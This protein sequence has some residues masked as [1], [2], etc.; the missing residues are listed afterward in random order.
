MP[1]LNYNTMRLQRWLLNMLSCN[2][3]RLTM[4]GINVKSDVLYVFYNNNRKDDDPTFNSEVLF[5]RCMNRVE[6]LIPNII[7][8]SVKRNFPEQRSFYYFINYQQQIIPQPP[9][10]ISRITS[11]IIPDSSNTTHNNSVKYQSMTD[12]DHNISV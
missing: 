6:K 12:N 7:S 4:V 2:N 1:R 11:Q 3:F 5:R 10:S 9:P 8:T